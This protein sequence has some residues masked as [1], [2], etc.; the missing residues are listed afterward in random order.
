VGVIF[1][2]GS[3][4]TIWMAVEVVR[5]GQ[6]S[7]WLWVIL[8]FG[9]VGAAVYFFSEYLDQP[10]FGWSGSHGRKVS[11][12]DL[13]VAEAE[14]HRLDNAATWLGYASALRA[15]KQ[16]PRAVEAAQKAV[17]RDASSVDAQ[18]ELAQALSAAGRGAE[19]VAPL[20]RVIATNRSFDSEA[21]LFALG[22]IHL[23]SGDLDGAR[24]ALEEVESRSSR[25][26]YLYELAI[27]LAQLGRRD[28][29]ARVLQ[30]LINE[31]ELV[32]PY[33][34]RSVKPWV[35]KSRQ[36]LRRLGF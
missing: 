20:Q 27:A 1:I 2:L 26:E 25:P 7:G 30:R 31:A 18:Y 34:K 35:R 24:A 8:V 4:F 5:R 29:A 22:K 3:A 12:G 14:V 15:R 11:A 10:L 17:E 21:A 23:A 28:E 13:R 16:Y 6:A 36:G 19:A 33:L 32:P 9:P